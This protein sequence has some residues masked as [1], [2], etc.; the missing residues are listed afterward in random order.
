MIHPDRR[1]LV[2]TREMLAQDMGMSMGTFR[3][4]RPYTQPGFPA[5]ISAAGARTLLWDGEQTDAFLAGETV[6]ALPPADGPGVLLDRQEAA[7]ELGVTPRTW[8]GYATD[9]RLHA[10]LVDIHGV[11][12]WPRG[13]VQAFRDSRPGKAAAS[14]RPKGSSD[15]VPRGELRDRISAL[16]DAEPAVTIADIQHATGAAYATVQRALTELRGERTA[17]LMT[18]DPTLSFEQAA[19][20]LGYPPALHRGIQSAMQRKTT[21]P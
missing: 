12:H 7:A 11:D 10:H 6:P 19:S 9:P 21:G 8:D 15:A 5:P 16:L 3:N 4:K 1:H 20:R 17:T 2:R 14:G 13:A 18:T